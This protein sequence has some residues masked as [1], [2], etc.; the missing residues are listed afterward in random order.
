MRR[1]GIAYWLVAAAHL[2]ACVARD[3]ME[4]AGA[5]PEAIRG[6]WAGNLALATKPAL[7]PLLS[8]YLGV[9]AARLRRSDI[10]LF[11]VQTA[12]WFSCAGDVA[13]MLDRKE[14]FGAGILAFAVAHAFYIYAFLGGINASEHLR[15]DRLALALPL[16]VFGYIVYGTVHPQLAGEP[17]LIRVGIVVYMGFL[18]ANA[19]S[20]FL[21]RLSVGA[22][23]SAAILVGATLFVE[24]DSLIALGRFG[25]EG[26]RLPLVG[27]AIMATYII[28]QYL[29]VRGCLIRTTEDD[30]AVPAA[31]LGGGPPGP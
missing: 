24:S 20:A 31:P 18:L 19:F 23:S 12:L 6:T 30:T 29:I 5:R 4:S 26:A 13:L 14:A 10:P 11:A 15:L 7:M 22:L 3:V 1:L 9:A 16:F 25:P 21:R 17:M 2:A 27:T 28:G 8:A